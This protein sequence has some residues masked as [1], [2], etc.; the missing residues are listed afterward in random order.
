MFGYVEPL[1]D[2]EEVGDGFVGDGCVGVVVE[3]L[4]VGEGG[5]ELVVEFGED[6]LGVKVKGGGMGR[7]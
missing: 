7:E 2:V 6:V 1:W 5:V 4:G 3:W